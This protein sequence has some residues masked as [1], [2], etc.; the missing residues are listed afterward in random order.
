MHLLKKKKNEDKEVLY[1]QSFSSNFSYFY[2]LDVNFK[3][4]TVKFHVPY[5]LNIHIKFCSNRKLFTI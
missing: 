3:N 5:V 2:F 1:E 4:L